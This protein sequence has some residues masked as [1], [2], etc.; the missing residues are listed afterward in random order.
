MIYRKKCR[1]LQI[2]RFAVKGRSEIGALRKYYFVDTGLRNA[3]LNFAYVFCKSIIL[4]IADKNGE[5]C[6]S[7]LEIVAG[8]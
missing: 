1:I 7:I 4:K 8:C 3:R 5:S 6:I 2:M